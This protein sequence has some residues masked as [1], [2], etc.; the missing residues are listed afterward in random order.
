MVVELEQPPW[1]GVFYGDGD[2]DIYGEERRAM[3]RVSN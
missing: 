2:D 1:P 3:I